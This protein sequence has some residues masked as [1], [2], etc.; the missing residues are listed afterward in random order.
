ML[1][2]GSAPAGA[3]PEDFYPAVAPAEADVATVAAAEPLS[4][5]PCF[6]VRANWNDALDGPQPVC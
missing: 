3:I 5:R 2:L 4:G 1:A 6:L